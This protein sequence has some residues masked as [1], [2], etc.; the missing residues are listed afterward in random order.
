[1]Y[2]KYYLTSLTVHLSSVAGSL[3]E[4]V[5]SG[6]KADK[7]RTV[8]P[9]R[10]LS[11]HESNGEMV[12]IQVR[13]LIKLFVLTCGVQLE[14]EGGKTV[15]ESFLCLNLLDVKGKKSLAIC[16]LQELYFFFFLIIQGVFCLS[17]FKFISCLF[18]YFSLSFPPPLAVHPFQ[19][20]NFLFS[21]YTV[22]S[23]AF[24]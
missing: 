12:K 24:P 9:P 8:K 23:L 13:F 10:S 22:F 4:Q 7:N 1:M 20:H 21:V 14:K 17:K 6:M 19:L 11:Q 15:M 3:L 18:C 2:L 16:P 5:S